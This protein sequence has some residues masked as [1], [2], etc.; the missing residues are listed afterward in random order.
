MNALGRWVFAGDLKLR[1]TNFLLIWVLRAVSGLAE[2]GFP[3]EA[4]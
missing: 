2:S 3:W 4:E 1:L